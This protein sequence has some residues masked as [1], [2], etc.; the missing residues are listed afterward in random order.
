MPYFSVNGSMDGYPPAPR[1][2]SMFAGGSPAAERFLLT[3]WDFS[4]SRL[5]RMKPLTTSAVNSASSFLARHSW[6]RVS[7]PGS[8]SVTSGDRPSPLR[9][10][11]ALCS[12]LALTKHSTPSISMPSSASAS[13]TVSG[14]LILPALR[15]RISMS[16]LTVAKLHLKATSPG[17]MSKP[18]PM[19]S[20]APLPL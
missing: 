10:R 12:V 8:Q 14:P 6:T 18:A 7:L 17:C 9:R 13:W 15:S 16:A 20:N 11:N 5:S 2:R 19:A 3:T 4:I 1:G